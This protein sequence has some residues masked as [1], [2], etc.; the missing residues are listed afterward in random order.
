ME[1]T[2]KLLHDTQSRHDNEAV[3]NDDEKVKREMVA[4]RP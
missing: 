4:R 1:I 3:F 2:Q